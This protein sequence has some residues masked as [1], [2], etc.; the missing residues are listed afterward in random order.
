MEQK[1]PNFL[2]LKK[3]RIFW[4]LQNKN[5]AANIRPH[6]LR[7]QQREM[8]SLRRI[9]TRHN[10]RRLFRNYPSLAV[11]FKI[12]LHRILGGEDFLGKKQKMSWRKIKVFTSTSK[13]KYFFWRWQQ[14]FIYFNYFTV[15]LIN[16][17]RFR[18]ISSSI[19]VWCCFVVW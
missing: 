1:V 12:P 19:S 7:F 15:S 4:P 9:N 8:L 18:E 16:V 17:M 14:S 5:K 3:G 2:S 6:N 13:A 11:S 10:C